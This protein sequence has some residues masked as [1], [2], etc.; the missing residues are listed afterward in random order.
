MVE[1]D[2]FKRRNYE[3]FK[4]TITIDERKKKLRIHNRYGW[5]FLDYLYTPRRNP[6]LD[7]GEYLLKNLKHYLRIFKN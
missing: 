5:S 7:N 6:K 1:Y 3:W 4:E 2:D